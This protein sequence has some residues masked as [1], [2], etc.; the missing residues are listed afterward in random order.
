MAQTEPGSYLA[1]DD[2]VAAV[3]IQAGAIVSKVIFRDDNVNVTVFGFD[4]GE[5]LT[6]HQAGRPAVGE[7]LRGRLRLPRPARSSTPGP[8]LAP[9][10]AGH[11]A[12]P[13]SHRTDGDAAHP[14]H[15]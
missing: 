1:I 5:E 2:V 14:D 8:D 12:L 15:P 11:T 7:V 10:G 6:E 3:T 9:H 4:T 13:E